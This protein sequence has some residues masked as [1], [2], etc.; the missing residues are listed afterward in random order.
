MPFL[1]KFEDYLAKPGR[2]SRR[3]AFGRI[4]KGCAV[5]AAT[6][7]GIGFYDTAYAANVACCNL[8]WPKNFCNSDYYDG[9]CPCCQKC[10]YA[11]VCNYNYNGHN[12]A[13]VCG[14][15]DQC[16]CSY[17]YQLCGTGCPCDPGAPSIDAIRT[18]NLPMRAMGEKCH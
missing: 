9:E 18:L 13:W 8:S 1:D 3:T 6:I 10:N 12:C 17:A 14:E 7:A 16:S 5:I 15:C 11:W 4:T 2:M